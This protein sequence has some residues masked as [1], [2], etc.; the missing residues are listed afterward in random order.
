MRFGTRNVEK[1]KFQGGVPAIH[2][3]EPVVPNVRLLTN[4]QRAILD[5]GQEKEWPALLDT[6]AFISVIPHDFV[7]A[8][9]CTANGRTTKLSGFQG[10]TGQEYDWYF[11]W[12]GL[13]GLPLLRTRAI[14]PDD[15]ALPQ[16]ERR[17]RITLGRDV[18]ARL[19]VFCRGSLPWNGFSLA[20]E[21]SWWRWSYR[22]RF[23][24]GVVDLRLRGIK[25]RPD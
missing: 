20:D 7:R 13:P 3:L 23:P 16:A 1:R 17:A 21:D 6:G 5:N 25:A 9:N 24:T 19:V 11:V 22:R 14:A 18:L 2:D 15:A 4:D 8:L 10:G 12:I